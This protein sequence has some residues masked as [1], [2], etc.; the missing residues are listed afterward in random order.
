MRVALLAVLC[1]LTIKTYSQCLTDFQKLLPEPS[2]DYSQDFGRSVAMHDK[3]MA[4]S[5]PNSDSLGR[6]TGLVYMYEKVNNTWKKIAT[7]FPSD[8]VDAL[9]F[10]FNMVLS[11]NYLIVGANSYGGKVYIFKKNAS[12]WTSQSELTSAKISGSYYFGANHYGNSSIAISQD[13]QTIAITDIYAP[14]TSNASPYYLGAV[15]VYHK[16]I[17]QEWN[18]SIIPS[19]IIAPQ[20]DIADFGRTGV[21]LYGNRL[22]TGSPY[23]VGGGNLWIYQDPSG[24]FTNFTIEATLRPTNILSYYLGF[25][26]LLFTQDGIFTPATLNTNGESKYGILFF[27]VPPSGNWVNSDPTCFIQ[28]GVAFTRLGNGKIFLS[29]RGT[30]ILASFR[31]ENGTGYL[32]SLMKGTTGWCAPEYE[33]I[34]ITPMLAGQGSNAYGLINASN[35]S[36][37]A[38]LGFVPI[39]GNVNATLALKTFTKTSNIWSNSLLYPSKKSTAGHFY[40][41]SILGFENHLFITSPGDGSVKSGG[42]AVYYYEKIGANWLRK[43]KITPPIS[44]QYDDRFGSALAS[45]KT[46]LAVGASG[47]TSGH[48]AIGR[49]FIYKKPDTGWPQAELVQEIALPEDQLI[50]YFYGDNLAMDDEWLV[51]PYIQNSPYRIM[52]AIYKFDGTIWNYHQAAEAPGLGNFFARSTTAAVS[53][54]GQTILAGNLILERNSQE[55][56]EVKHTLSPS[57]PEPIQISSDFTH[58]I[59]NGSNFGLSNAISENTIFVGAPTKDF[60]GTWDVGAVYVYTKNPDQSWSSMTETAKLLPRVKDELELFGYSL[61][62]YNNTVL[63]GAPGADFNKDGVTARNKP[64]R[65]YVF[66]SKDFYWQDVVPLIDITGDSFVKDYYGIDVYMDQSDFFI[67]AAIEDIGT[68]KLSGSVYITP[69]P[70]IIKLVPPVCSSETVIDLFG[71]PFG[72]TW[73]GPGIID[74][75]EGIFDPKIAGTGIHEFR[76]RTPNCAYEGILKIEVLD[77]PIAKLITST[78]IKVCKGVTFSVPL[79]VEVEN[80]VLYSWYF[81]ENSSQAFRPLNVYASSLSANKLGEYQLKV[82]YKVCETLTPVITIADEEVNIELESPIKICQDDTT[83]LPLV[84]TPAGGNWSGTGVVNN[85]FIAA[86]LNVGIYK[87]TYKYTSTLGCTFLSEA[88]VIITAAYKPTIIRSTGNLCNEGL[89]TLALQ[90]NP[91]AGT[92]LTW[93]WENSPDSQVLTESGQSIEV[94][95][96]GN[97]TVISDNGICKITSL[98]N[99]NDKLEPDITPSE[100]YVEVCAEDEISLIVKEPQNANFSWFFKKS[101]DGNFQALNEVSESITILESGYYHVEIEK[102]VCNYISEPKQFVIHPKDSIFVPNV[103]TPNGDNVNEVFKTT[104]TIDNAELIILN[105]YGSRMFT[106]SASQGWTGDDASSGVYFWLVQYESCRKE[107]KTVKGSVHLIR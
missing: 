84:A 43:S 42:G 28:P 48:A 102:G 55:I 65:A 92:Y 104:G 13:E 25:Y 50:V 76:Y 3:Y 40:G 78:D 7:L 73:V 18:G 57:D 107:K 36:D 35:Q 99:L 58:L 11:E 72:G 89:V 69:S 77:P 38:A 101:L 37:E 10:G 12:G 54:Y 83:P 103:F 70:P 105:R 67:G 44:G 80:N 2:I 16:Q 14:I 1:L 24:N 33:T 17:F 62:S 47:Y 26:N 23:T 71:Y 86:N 15:Y 85:S 6:L 82:F 34:D 94:N 39:P 51:I 27:Q 91:P 68:G 5:M 30:E 22:V 63:A 106:G 32:N 53:I 59:T 88:D 93:I 29:S 95:R 100:N 96:Q 81:R 64:G 60:E 4:I 75:A 79:S 52:L 31:D 49:V 66:Q 61:Q 9:Q 87:I 21:A 8:P 90:Q 19:R 46:Y 45:N 98:I 20:A 97:Y 56:W 74:A 41:Q